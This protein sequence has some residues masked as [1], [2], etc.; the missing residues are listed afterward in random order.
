MHG[1]ESEAEIKDSELKFG[2]AVCIFTAVTSVLAVK[3][4]YPHSLLEPV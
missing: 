4:C 1:L 3:G 2:F